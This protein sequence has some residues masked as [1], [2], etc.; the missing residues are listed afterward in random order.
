MNTRD[1]IAKIAEYL[2]TKR[3]IKSK[4][5]DDLTM[6]T[7]EGKK[8]LAYL[9]KKDEEKK[10][11]KEKEQKDKKENKEKEQKEKKGKTAADSVVEDG[12][13]DINETT[14]NRD[15]KNS[16]PGEIAGE[17][18]T[19]SDLDELKK[20]QLSK[21]P[22]TLVAE[23]VRSAYKRAIKLAFMR[24]SNNLDVNPHEIKASLY[25]KLEPLMKAARIKQ[26]AIIAAIEAA[27]EQASPK[28]LD[29]L[30]K[31]ADEISELGDEAIADMEN[32]IKMTVTL[33][34]GTGDVE[35]EFRPAD[36]E[37]AE[38]E[39]NE[40]EEVEERLKEGSFRLPKSGRSKESSLASAMPR[41][42]ISGER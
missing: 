19:G 17:N 40:A 36:E 18:A 35:G 9:S 38:T 22:P 39:E 14:S 2:K 30:F 3:A 42:N 25:D 20:E 21:A 26:T 24:F 16:E 8:I 7:A 6:K 1:R 23:D 29:S 13:K 34:P 27:F 32:T 12:E 15:Y 33:D 4:G 31:R 41:Y 28:F 37:E 10:E 5:T 11:N